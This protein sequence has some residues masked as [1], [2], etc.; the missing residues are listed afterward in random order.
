MGRAQYAAKPLKMHKATH[1][2]KELSGPNVNGATVEKP[3]SRERTGVGGDT[4]VRSLK[5]PSQKKE[6][7]TKKLSGGSRTL[8]AL[9][10]HPARPEVVPHGPCLTRM[11]RSLLGALTG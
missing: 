2:N 5:I 8:T 6:G 1:Y 11:K 7:S 10:L 3:C 9:P 4:T